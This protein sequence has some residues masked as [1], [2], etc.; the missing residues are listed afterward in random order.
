MRI[1]FAPI[2]IAVLAIA[3]TGGGCRP[4]PGHGW[5]RVDAAAFTAELSAPRPGGA[6]PDVIVDVREPELFRKGHIPGAINLPWPDAKRRAPAELDPQRDIVVVCH[7]GPMGDEL[8]DILVRNGFRRVRNVAGG[9]AAWRG[10][11]VQGG[12]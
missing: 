12:S 9:M 6:Q 7:T 1:R 3:L 2:H 11:V 5:S 10:P 4:K 8:A